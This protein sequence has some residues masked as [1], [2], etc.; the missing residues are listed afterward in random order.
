[1]K[2]PKIGCWISH[3]PEG[4]VCANDSCGAEK[5]AWIFGG[6]PI[7]VSVITIFICNLI[8]YCHVRSTV[9]RGQARALAM[10]ERMAAYNKAQATGQP[11]DDDDE[12]DEE[13]D[14]IRK[15]SLS[16][17][18]SSRFSSISRSSL[19]SER[20]RSVLRSSDREW[21]RVKEVGKQS[22]LYVG[23]YFLC[24]IW[25][26]LKGSLDGQGFDKIEGSGSIFFPL[27]VLQSFFLPIHGFFR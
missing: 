26:I 14:E 9:K 18:L 12:D 8:L 27:V 19:S 20:P 22:F 6:L 10:E 25:G 15:P 4:D 7:L 17:R 3:P 5:M 1:M 23:S 13:E 21:Q 16:K 2:N 11:Q 24:F